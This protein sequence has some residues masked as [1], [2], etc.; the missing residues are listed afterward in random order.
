[1]AEQPSTHLNRRK[2]WWMAQ[3]QP[4]AEEHI[5]ASHVDA[6]YR[7]GE[8]VMFVLLW[9]S[10]DYERGEV[11]RCPV[12]ID[13]DPLSVGYDRSPSNDCPACFGTSF[14]GG[15]RARIVRPAIIGDRNV[16][17]RETQR[18][19]QVTTE[20]LSLQTTSDFYARTGDFMFRAD[21]TRYQLSQM[22]TQ[23]VRSGFE[24]PGQEQSVGGLINTATLESNLSALAHRLPPTEAVVRTT[25][26]QASMDRHLVVGTGRFDDVR[27]S[28][29]P[30]S[31]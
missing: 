19:G 22:E 23:V 29:V 17:T 8:F 24:H 3:N 10:D 11:K 18:A 25:L 14:E 15:Y 12:C 20:T 7:Y 31:S 4:W 13:G 21:G 9:H 28:L 27:G 30:A 26:E 5:A 6:L 1:M 2:P 16:E